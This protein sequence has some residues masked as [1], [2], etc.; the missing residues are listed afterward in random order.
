MSETT[1]TQKLQSCLDR[2][3]NGD[4]AARTELFEQATERLYAL[5]RKIRKDFPRVKNLVETGDIAGDV[6]I[7]LS[8]SLERVRPETVR[9]LYGFVALQIRRQLIDL[10]RKQFGRGNKPRGPDQGLGDGSTP[11]IRPEDSTYD[12]EKLAIWAEFHE[13]V[14]KLPPE[15]REVVDLLWYQE[16]SQD[17]AAV[18][19][20]VDKSTV[21]RRWRRAR[22]KLGS[23]LGGAVPES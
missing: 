1:R 14:E 4:P 7:R 12:P 17:E 5:A 19:L 9:D 2:L 10:C 8:T 16:L 21:K 22:M 11:G 23:I 6:Y 20:A 15:E 3:R 13:A 18:V